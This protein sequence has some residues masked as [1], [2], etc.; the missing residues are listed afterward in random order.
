[1]RILGFDPGTLQMGIGLVD[2]Q[3]GELVTP[4]YVC[5][6]VPK[7]DLIEHRLMKLF[8]QIDRLLSE[9]K[10]DLIAVED[11]FVSKN[12]KTAIAIGQAQATILIAG[13]KHGI[14]ITR[15]APKEIKKSI[16]DYGG[17]SKDQVADMVKVILGNIEIEGPNDITDALAVAIC[18]HNRIF[19]D[20]II[21]EQ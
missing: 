11:P 3:N 13:A 6:K 1:M 18:H 5:L 12:P 8:D 16:T 15:Y 20:Q 21:M 4:Y 9:L 7:N 19:M 14:P 10:P 17:A 2:S